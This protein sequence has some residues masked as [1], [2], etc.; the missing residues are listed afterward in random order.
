MPWNTTWPDGTVSV[1]D[2]QPTGQQNTTYVE[3]T[4]NTDHFFNESAN[5]D[6]HHR[7]V[8]CQ[9]SGTA[10]TP[11][12]IALATDM[13][14]AYYVRAKSAAES[15]ANQDVQPFYINNKVVDVAGTTQVMQLLGMRACAVFTGQLVNGA[16]TLVYSHNV[17]SVT[18]T[19]A[20]NYT[21][22]Y[23][24]SLPSENYMV[25][26]DCIVN[27]SSPGLLTLQQGAAVS[28]VKTT[29]NLK[30]RTFRGSASAIDPVQ[31]WFFCFGG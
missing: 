25:Q 14:G 21:V 11:T 2:N 3:T 7:F 10:A 23:T 13:D 5:E 27:N 6:G 8:Q 19:S 15:T 22:V 28:D 17:A 29:T 26:G 20:G 18:R 1:E 12:D 30:L 9:K 16:C 31:G 4:I 24:D